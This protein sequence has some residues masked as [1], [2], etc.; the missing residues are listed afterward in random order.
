MSPAFEARAPAAASAYPT[1]PTY[2]TYP[3][4][5][6]DT[7]E[8]SATRSTSAPSTHSTSSSTKHTSKPEQ[9]TNDGDVSIGPSATDR[10]SQSQ[11]LPGSSSTILSPSFSVSTTDHDMAS[12]AV[13]ASVGI[14][15]DSSTSTDIA[16]PTLGTTESHDRQ[17]TVPI[18]AIAISAIFG[19]LISIG[20]GLFIFR[21]RRST[22]V[23]QNGGHAP[24]ASSTSTY[25]EVSESGLT[26]R[27][28][29]APAISP[30]AMTL[31]MSEKGGNN[32]RDDSANTSS[33]QRV[34]SSMFFQSISHEPS[35][36]PKSVASDTR[37]IFDMQSRGPSIL[38]DVS[39]VADDD[40]RRF[41]AEQSLELYQAM[42][43][44]GFSPEALLS[45]LNRIQPILEGVASSSQ[46]ESTPQVVN[47]GEEAAP[48]RYTYGPDMSLSSPRLT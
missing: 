39:S 3:V 29:V 48:P 16:V 36:C 37:S 8:P 47:R 30:F 7:N 32:G 35:I 25:F 5:E 20:L 43:R 14:R 38:G 45:S 21:R 40:A 12:D 15:S 46:S 18:V 22:R 4:S 42:R 19:I 33:R 27:P 31:S 6:T 41:Q 26:P 34:N 10:P 24:L 1:Y 23:A 28:F 13:L 44:A 2:P 9:S 17:R 11:L